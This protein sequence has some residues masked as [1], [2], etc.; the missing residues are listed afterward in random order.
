[1]KCTII[2]FCPYAIEEKRPSVVPYQ[3]NL[4]ASDGNTPAVLVIDNAITT[5]DQVLRPEALLVPIPS[6]QLAED[7]VTNHVKAQVE[8]AEDAQ[9]AL[10]WLP[11]ALTAKEVL[12]Q[13]KETVSFYI[14]KQVAWF[15]RLVKAADDNWNKNKQRRFISDKYII[16][17]EKLGLKREWAE[18]SNLTSEAVSTIKLIPC[19]YCTYQILEAAIICINCKQV[20]NEVGKKALDSQHQQLA[21]VG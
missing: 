2:S 9:P 11:G 5:L 14:N 12:Q 7:L 17:A 4:A 16:A 18:L 1:M 8:Y 19:P 20:V 6:E 21:K 15:R 10:F 13:H 3:Y